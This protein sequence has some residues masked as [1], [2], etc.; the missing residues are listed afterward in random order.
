MGFHCFTLQRILSQIFEILREEKT[1]NLA[2]TVILFISGSQQQQG[3][4]LQ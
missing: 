2:K 4:W 1:D 3:N